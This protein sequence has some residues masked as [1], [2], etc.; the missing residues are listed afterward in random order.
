MTAERSIPYFKEKI[1]PLL[2][3]GKNVFISA[4]GNSL[5]S[6]IMYLDK[7]TEE[8]VLHLEIATG[9]PI[10]YD[11]SKGSFKKEALTPI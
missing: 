11:Y 5:R 3:Q 6:I 4:H 1:V 9:A 8:Q 7:L 10:I 2:Q